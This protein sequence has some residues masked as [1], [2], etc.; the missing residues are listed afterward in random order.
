MLTFKQFLS[1]IF[2]P[3]RGGEHVL[4]HPEMGVFSLVDTGGDT[5]SALVDTGSR[6]SVYEMSGFV[7]FES[8]ELKMCGEMWGD[9]G[10]SRQSIP[11]PPNTAI[12]PQP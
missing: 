5:R 10:L 6:G 12:C 4:D 8:T 3:T 2:T 11:K 7:S 9:V 1:E